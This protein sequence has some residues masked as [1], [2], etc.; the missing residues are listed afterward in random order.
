MV[1]S[2][3]RSLD[4]A[5]LVPGMNE[6]PCR[7]R[8]RSTSAT[9]HS[10]LCHD[11]LPKLTK[12]Q[13]YSPGVAY[14]GYR[15]Y[16]PV[17]GRW[18]SRDPARELSFISSRVKLGDGDQAFLIQV[19]FSNHMSFN[20]YDFVK[21]NPVITYDQFGLA[22]DSCA[23]TGSQ[24]ARFDNRF[25]STPTGVTWVRVCIERNCKWRCYC[26][27]TKPCYKRPCLNPICHINNSHGV[28]E[29]VLT[30]SM[31]TPTP[32]GPSSGPRDCTT[33]KATAI[34]RGICP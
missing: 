31:T 29:V 19:L 34:A 18:P 28:D 27:K 21:N 33:T 12:L 15:W 8:K 23:S 22:Y 7:A 10:H 13:G 17:T 20:D 3:L 25:I 2:A 32:Y 16:D 14:Y 24:C 26:S 11:S 30:S 9:T 6:H 4:R 1:F 5:T